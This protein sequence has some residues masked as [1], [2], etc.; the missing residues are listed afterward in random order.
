M[1]AFWFLHE[2]TQ[3]VKGDG[4]LPTGRSMEGDKVPRQRPRGTKR[5]KRDA[6]EE[7]IGKRTLNGSFG[8]MVASTEKMNKSMVLKARARNATK[9][10]RVKLAKETFMW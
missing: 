9:M 3:L 8:S 5:E 6:K 1:E 7:N 2:N 10:Y 4:S